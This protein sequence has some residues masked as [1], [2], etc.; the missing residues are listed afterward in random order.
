MEY[1]GE[2]PMLASIKVNPGAIE[3]DTIEVIK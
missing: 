3:F 1:G 2:N